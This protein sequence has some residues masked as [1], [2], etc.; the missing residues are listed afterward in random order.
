[1]KL[2]AQLKLLTTEEQS[3]Q[4][5]ETLEAANR[6]CDYISEWCWQNKTFGKFKIQKAIY[7]DVRAKFSLSAQMAIRAIAKVTDAYKLDKKTQRTFSAHGA[8]AYDQRIL[9]YKLKNHQVS[10]LSLAG[11]L[12]IDFVTGQKQLEMLKFQQGESDLVYR[13]GVFYLFATCNVEE[14]DQ[15]DPE[16]A[17]GIDMGII[18]IATDSD[19]ERHSGS[20][21]LSLRKRRR[22]Q[23]KRL[24][25][26]G[27]PSAKR[28]LKKLSGR[29][30]R[31]AKDVNHCLSK[32]IVQ[33]AKDTNRAIALE[34]LAG[35]R[36]RARL[37]K[38]QR[39]ELNSWA[40][41]QLGEFILYK[42]K[43]EGV[44]V[45]FID[46]KYTSQACSQCG[47][48]DKSNR[49]NQSTFLCVSCGFAALADANAATNIAIRGWGVV[50]HPNAT[51]LQGSVAS[52]RALA[53]GS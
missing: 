1:M 26:K 8:I 18:N 38:P 31:F 13:N 45:V 3:R 29:E 21:V 22:R 43:R 10:I 27:T 39:T 25:K 40:F 51:G 52:P 24:Q 32:K 14:P 6:A 42:A 23:R 16:G 49:K 33:K 12:K 20:Q 41:S 5:L 17:L 11:R 30:S 34:D 4:L 36:D 35:I 7:Q 50:N 2:I 48:I 28:R 37:R 44:P 9:S 53:G 15:I 47:C 46:P 19:G